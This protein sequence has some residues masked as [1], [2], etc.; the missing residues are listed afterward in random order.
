MDN[1]ACIQARAVKQ[2]FAVVTTLRTDQ[3]LGLTEV[4]TWSL[5]HALAEL[6]WDSVTHVQGLR[7]HRHAQH[8]CTLRAILTPHL[9]LMANRV[10]IL[11]IDSRLPPDK[12]QQ[13]A[14]GLAC[15]IKRTNGD[16]P[17]VVLTVKGDLSEES[18]QAVRKVATLV[19]VEDFFVRSL[20]T[21][22]CGAPRR[23]SARRHQEMLTCVAT[24]QILWHCWRL[25]NKSD[26]AVRSHGEV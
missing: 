24:M 15:S 11:G 4:R 26:A 14:Q 23:L 18:E 13:H 25:N 3:Y 9:R 20:H 5:S 10:S 2:R 22:R 1:Y 8:T 19:H 16:L 21:Q 6:H 7:K 17:L 12:L